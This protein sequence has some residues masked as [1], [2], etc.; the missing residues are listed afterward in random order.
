MKTVVFGASSDIGVA[1]CAKYLEM[2]WDVIAVYRSERKDLFELKQTSPYNIELIRHTFSGADSLNN[3][4]EE[5]ISLYSLCDA[6]VNCIG[7]ANPKKYEDILESDVLEHIRINT[8]PN[9]VLTQFFSSFMLERAWGRF[10]YI[11]S[12]GVKFSGGVENYCYSMSKLLTEFFPSVAKNYW[13]QENVFVNAVRAGYIDTRFHSQFTTKSP[14]ERISLI[15]AKRAGKPTEV[16][17]AVFFLG[18]ERNTFTT[19]E[20]LAV[21]GGE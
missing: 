7:T 6:V 5:N 17:E 20:V 8:I 11:S 21:S 10:V 19:C 18:S 1:V 4:L 13:A 9:I 16:A 14:S 12:I 2:G 3:H 15:P